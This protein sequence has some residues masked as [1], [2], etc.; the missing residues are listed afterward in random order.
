MIDEKRLL[1]VFLGLVAIDSPSGQERAIGDELARRL[2]QTLGGQV[3]RDAHGNIIARFPEGVGD[4]LLLSA[5]MDTVG[6]DIG[7]KPQIRDGV[8][9]SDGSTILC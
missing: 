2:S 4:W 8:V 7:I 6:K 5:H 9:Y 3:E 1:Q